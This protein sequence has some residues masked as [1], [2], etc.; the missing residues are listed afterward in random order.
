MISLIDRTFLLRHFPDTILETLP[1][2]I[3]LKGLGA[4]SLDQS[5]TILITIRSTEGTPYTFLVQCGIVDKLSCGLLVGIPFLRPYRL[6]IEW[7]QDDEPDYLRLDDGTR[8]KVSTR[9]HPSHAH[10]PQSMPV[11]ARS[12][13]TIPPGQ[14]L[15]VP[16]RPLP[17]DDATELQL[18]CSPVAGYYCDSYCSAPNA[19]V[20]GALISLPMANFG[21]FPVKIS[22]GQPLGRV[23][24]VTMTTNPAVFAAARADELHCAIQLGDLL[25]PDGPAETPEDPKRP[26]GYPFHIYS[27]EDPIDLSQADIS[28]AWGPDISQSILRVVYKYGQLFNPKIG[29]FNDGVTIPILFKS[30]ADIS[31]LAQRPYNLLRRD[32]KAMDSVLNPLKEAGIVEDVL[33]GEGS[34]VSSPS[35]VVWRA[36][37]PRVVMDLRR[38][39]SK[40]VGNTYPLPR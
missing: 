4:T 19:L 6:H 30:D 8:F 31:D 2:D 36:D 15:H 34:P 35:F 29:R 26:D 27:E 18:D 11:Y 33:L 32:K 24:P 16:V 7:G 1:T 37:K 21:L 40:L 20:I 3:P 39:N 13:Y 38:V 25:G 28:D 22:K 23:S 17:Y 10:L 12:A 5:C 9:P 14:G